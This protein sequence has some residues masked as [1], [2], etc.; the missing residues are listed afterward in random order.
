MISLHALYIFCQLSRFENNT[1]T[2]KQEENV[3]LLDFSQ[4]DKRKN[5]FH[6]TVH[7]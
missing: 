4:P 5:Q 1:D 6:E 2:G 3:D 7:M